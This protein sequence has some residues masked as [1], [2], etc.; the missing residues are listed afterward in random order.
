MPSPPARSS[1]LLFVCPQVS[2][3]DAT[4]RPELAIRG[5]TD[6]NGAPRAHMTVM[7]MVLAQLSEQAD[8]PISD[9]H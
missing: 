9:D 7:Q 1:R 2:Q 5:A 4:A 6:R 3:L 8:P